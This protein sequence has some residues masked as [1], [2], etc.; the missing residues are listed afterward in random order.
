MHSTAVLAVVQVEDTDFLGATDGKKRVRIK[1]KVDPGYDVRQVRP[2]LLCARPH[3]EPP[4][5]LLLLEVGAVSATEAYLI[6]IIIWSH[7]ASTWCTRVDK[8]MRA[9]SHSSNCAVAGL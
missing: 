4:R 8:K 7:Q 5:S 1:K 6:C 9:V 3:A 2:Q